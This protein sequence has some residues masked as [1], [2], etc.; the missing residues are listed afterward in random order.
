[1]VQS[2]HLKRTSHTHNT[3]KHT[4]ETNTSYTFHFPADICGYLMLVSDNKRSIF[5]YIF[6]PSSS[7]EERREEGY[8]FLSSAEFR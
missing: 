7:R 3:E 4:T 8:S 5:F 2:T 1:M 6:L